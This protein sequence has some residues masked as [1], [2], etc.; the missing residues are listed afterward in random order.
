ME[1]EP[2]EEEEDE[3]EEGHEPQVKRGK[4]LTTSSPTVGSKQEIS[5]SIKDPNQKNGVVYWKFFNPGN[6]T[7]LELI[8]GKLQII[9]SR[10]IQMLIESV[11]QGAKFIKAN[12][13]V[14]KPNDTYE[15]IEYCAR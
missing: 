7:F 12:L 10:R 1:I 6:R 11:P 5:I 14:Q 3:E 15:V 13:Y 9:G 8:D 4:T 2:E